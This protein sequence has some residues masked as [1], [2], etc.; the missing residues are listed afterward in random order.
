LKLTN[1]TRDQD[2]DPF[3]QRRAKI[4][5][6]IDEQMKLARAH[7]EGG[8][9]APTKR[10]SL[11]DPET[12]L[13]R[14]V[15]VPKRVKPWWFVTGT[16]KVALTVR[17]GA[18]VLELA[19]GKTAIELASQADVVTTLEIIKNAVASGEFDAL[20]ERASKSLREGFGE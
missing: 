20:L 7:T 17:Y 6:R 13:R 18:R 12:G 16:G 1:A 19:K 2:R 3:Q 11:T 9:F 14:S 4:T 10:R 15:E 5:Q 8:S